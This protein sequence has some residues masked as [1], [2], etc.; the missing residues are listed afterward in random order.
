[1]EATN[2]YVERPSGIGTRLVVRIPSP[3]C[4]D[5][6]PTQL[7]APEVGVVHCGQVVVNQRVGVDEFQRT[8]DRHQ[9]WC[10]LP[11]RF[12]R[13][14]CRSNG[15][16]RADSLS[17]SHETVPHAFMQGCGCGVDG[18]THGVQKSID[19]NPLLFEVVL[20]AHRGVKAELA[21]TGS[22]SAQSGTNGL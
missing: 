6:T 12:C 14:F 17:S 11:Y 19:F 15:Q 1:M 20:D 2:D 7:F 13:R 21:A 18:G 8:G 22:E 4:A 9:S 3:G 16:D 5:T 10:G